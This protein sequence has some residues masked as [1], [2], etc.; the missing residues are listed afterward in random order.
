M[1]SILALCL[2]ALAACGGQPAAPQGVGPSAPSEPTSLGKRADIEIEAFAAK[3]ATGVTVVDVRTDEEWVTGH[4]P[5]AIH[6]PITE[7]SP[8]HPEIAKLPKGEPIYV[9]CAVGGRSARAADQLAA[10][11][12]KAVSVSGGTQAWIANHHPIEV[13]GAT[14]PSPAEPASGDAAPHP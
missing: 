9:V 4:V 14:P 12:Y 7:L 8:T 1:K 2:V 6:V 3:H 11:G 5:G 13:P 10:V